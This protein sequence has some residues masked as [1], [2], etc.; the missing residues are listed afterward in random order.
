MILPFLPRK[1]SLCLSNFS[2]FQH[3]GPTKGHKSLQ[4]TIQVAP[5]HSALSQTRGCMLPCSWSQ[6][7][8]A[9]WGGV[10][11]GTG[12]DGIPGD[13]SSSSAPDQVYEGLPIFTTCRL[14][15][16]GVAVLQAGGIRRIQCSL[17]WGRR[18][19]IWLN[20]FDC[21]AHFP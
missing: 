14:E 3:L 8:V 17:G 12:G 19:G 15:N 21:G 1:S 16:L 11:Y 18:W 6:L 10:V 13:P 20:L 2:K 7:T 9:G 5:A 4:K